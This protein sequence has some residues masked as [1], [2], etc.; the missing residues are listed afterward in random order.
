MYVHIVNIITANLQFIPHPSI[1]LLSVQWSVTASTTLLSPAA[2]WS[3]AGS[4]WSLT[5]TQTALVRQAAA[6]ETPKEA[7]YSAKLFVVNNYG[8]LT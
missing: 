5:E 6:E 3:T 2:V 4:R 1:S 8:D 7:K